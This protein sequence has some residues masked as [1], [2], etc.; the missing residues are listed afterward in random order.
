MENISQIPI[1]VAE[2]FEQGRRRAVKVNANDDYTLN[3]TFDNNEVRRY[4][5]LQSL[6]G[7]VFEP[8][9]DMSNFKRVYIDEFG[10]ISW[11]LANIGGN[12][13]A[14]KKIDLCSD[15]CYIYSESL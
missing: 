4:N 3:I 15:S 9:K 5:M 13:T 1:E 8:L 12:K 11:K 7:K 14:T 10:C 6:K 2:Y